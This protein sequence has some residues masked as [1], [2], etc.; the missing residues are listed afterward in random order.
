M[1]RTL[2]FSLVR[3]APCPDGAAAGA[4]GSSFMLRDFIG[5]WEVRP[6]GGGDGRSCEVEHQLSVLPGMPVPP[7]V[8]YYMRSIF[9]RQ[10]DRILRD[11]QAGVARQQQQQQQE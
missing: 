7:V 2:R 5:R 11:L 4:D 10:V 6:L 3:R 9:V 8:S 1:R